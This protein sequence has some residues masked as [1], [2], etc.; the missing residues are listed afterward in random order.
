MTSEAVNA[1]SFS[2]PLTGKIEFPRIQI[3]TV[4]E[5]LRGKIPNLPQGL[6]ENYYKEAEAIDIE[7]NQTNKIDL[8]F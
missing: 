2:T 6:V 3:I 1:G 7:E 4:K 5:L 8:K